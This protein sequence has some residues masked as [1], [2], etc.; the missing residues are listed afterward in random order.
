[1]LV[2]SRTLHVQMAHLDTFLRVLMLVEPCFLARF[3]EFTTGTV[4]S[5][6]FCCFHGGACS[7]E[8]RMSNASGRC[9]LRSPP[10]DCKLCLTVAACVCKHLAAQAARSDG[11]SG[12]MAS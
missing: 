7:F 8:P 4:S 11:A 10:F 6:F 3:A 5:C 9:N 1:M 12:Q 2:L